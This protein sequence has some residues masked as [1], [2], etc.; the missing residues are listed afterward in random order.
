MT[1]LAFG[2]EMGGLT[3]SSNLLVVNQ[4]SLGK[5]IGRENPY[6][7]RKERRIEREDRKT[8]MWNL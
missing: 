6:V 1:F 8:V 4:G 3:A 5:D 7:V 2:E